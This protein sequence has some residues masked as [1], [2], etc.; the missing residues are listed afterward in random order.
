LVGRKKKQKQK[1]KKTSQI[2]N[3]INK[4]RKKKFLFTCKSLNGSPLCNKCRGMMKRSLLKM[5]A[6]VEALCVVA[7]AS[8]K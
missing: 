5:E 1:Q 3:F 2:V 6:L 4:A 8:V 7:E